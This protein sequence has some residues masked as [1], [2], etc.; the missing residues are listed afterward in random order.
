MHQ[1]ADV[2]AHEL[3]DIAP[4]M[5]EL[6]LIHKH[7]N[8]LDSS[9][10]S[11]DPP[12]QAVTKRMRALSDVTDQPL[13]VDL[14]LDAKVLLPDNVAREAAVAAA[15][16][17]RLTPAPLGV[18]A[19]REYHGRFLERYGPGAIVSVAQLTSAAAG[20]GF[21]HHFDDRQQP[22][23]YVNSRDNQLLTLAHEAATNNMGELVLDADTMNALAPP[24]TDTH[25]QTVPHVDVWFDLRAPSTTALDNGEFTLAICGVGRSAAAVGRFVDDLPKEDR[26]QLIRAYRKLPTTTDGALPVQLSFPPKTLKT[27]NTLRAPALWPDVISLAEHPD[28][29]SNPIPLADLAVTADQHRFYLVSTSR[30]RVVEPQIPHAGARHTMPALARFLFELPRATGPAISPFDWGSASC[31]PFLPRV[32]YGRSILA[33]AR[34]R[35]NLA[36]SPNPAMPHD[37]WAEALTELLNRRRIPTAISVGEDDR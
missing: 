1:L 11:N 21:P 12:R 36:D 7:L 26:D 31:L 3:A 16:L 33:P 24:E 2:A 20:I 14:H 22:K 6:H 34:W 29:D 9:G 37:E 35:L 15:A 10:W 13:M 5:D 28:D 4:L 32:R 17:L 27:E 23:R 30:R 19:W 8:G 25:T 18:A